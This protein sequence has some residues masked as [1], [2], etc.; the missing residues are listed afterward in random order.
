MSQL[1]FFLFLSLFFFVRQSKPQTGSTVGA[2]AW[3][4]S[5]SSL[6]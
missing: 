2:G 6:E 4:A 3:L 1:V 5:G